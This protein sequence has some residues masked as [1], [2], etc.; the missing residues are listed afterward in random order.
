[1]TAARLFAESASGEGLS[2]PVEAVADVFRQLGTID[3]NLA[4]ISRVYSTEEAAEFFSKSPQWLYWAMKPRDEGGGGLFYHEDGR[5]IEPQRI[6]KRGIRRFTLEVIKDM[7]VSMY[8][9]GT[10]KTPELQEIIR[11]IHLARLGR[12]SPQPKEG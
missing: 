2:V 12:W 5:L 10:I 6:G 4:G 1:M 11:R 8:Q 7:S 9:R 3:I